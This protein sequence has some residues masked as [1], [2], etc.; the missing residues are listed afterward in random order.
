[1]ETKNEKFGGRNQTEI[2]PEKEEEYFLFLDELRESGATNMFGGAP[3]LQAVF[4]E[5]DQKA[6]KKILVKWMETF[7]KRYPN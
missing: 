6:A 2:N 4:P 5:L 7:G 1:M 3:Y